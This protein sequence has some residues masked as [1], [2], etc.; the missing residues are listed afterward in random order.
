M[1]AEELKDYEARL[2]EKVQP[3]RIRT[4]LGFAGLYQLTHELIKDVVV[5]KLREYYV[6]DL[7]ESSVRAYQ[8]RVYEK[9]V[10]SR[11]PKSPFRASLLWLVDAGAITQEQADRLDDIYAHRH[12]LTHELAKYLVDPDFEP[13]IGLF[14]DA[15]VILSRIY[16][17]WTEVDL[18]SGHLEAPPGVTASDIKARPLLMLEMCIAAY[19]EGFEIE[20]EHML[21]SD[22][23]DDE[24]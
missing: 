12:D 18:D 4:T 17:F 23:E 20:Q 7:G 15:F 5:P 11:A 13:K 24:S 22:D 19:L 6:N 8:E 21:K 9:H 2:E 1:N 14:Q 16:R 10:L 3:W